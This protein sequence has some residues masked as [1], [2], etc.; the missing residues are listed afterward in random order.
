MVSAVVS[1]GGDVQSSDAL[2]MWARV[3]RSGSDAANESVARR[4]VYSAHGIE[5]HQVDES[6]QLDEDGA[7]GLSVESQRSSDFR[8]RGEVTT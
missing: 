3:T 8:F 1:G 7:S 6:P 4:C 5:S 2:D